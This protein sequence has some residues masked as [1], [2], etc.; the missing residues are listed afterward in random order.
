M[1]QL[2]ISPENSPRF[3]L[4]SSR[5]GTICSHKPIRQRSKLSPSILPPMEKLSAAVFA[6]LILAEYDCRLRTSV[7]FDDAPLALKA[8]VRSLRQGRPDCKS[9]PSFSV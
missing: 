6:V 3:V 9:L 1:G 8:E 2:R 7:K 5:S 4:G